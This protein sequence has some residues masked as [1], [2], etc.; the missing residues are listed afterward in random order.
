MSF[1]GSCAF[2]DCVAFERQMLLIYF[3]ANS[4]IIIMPNQ[5]QSRGWGVRGRGGGGLYGLSVLGQF[6]SISQP[7][8]VKGDFASH[9]STITFNVSPSQLMYPHHS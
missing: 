6:G 4:V 1:V 9:L 5:L 3:Y 7:S 8:V 2:C